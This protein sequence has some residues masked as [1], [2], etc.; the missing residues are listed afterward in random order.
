MGIV[1]E[2]GDQP[3]AFMGWDESADKF[4]MGVAQDSTTNNI[5]SLSTGDLTIV[6]KDLQ[7]SGI[8]ATNLTGTILTAAQPN[9]TTVGT[10]TT[11]TWN[12]DTISIAKGDRVPPH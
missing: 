8:V 7:V 12:A 3:N 9:I 5:T 1:M 2:R 6:Q 11:G 10:I 4:I